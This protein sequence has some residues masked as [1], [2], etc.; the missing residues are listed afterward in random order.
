[1]AL[2][3]VHGKKAFTDRRKLRG[4]I[5]RRACEPFFRIFVCRAKREDF[6]R[7]EPRVIFTDGGK[8]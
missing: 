3:G 4:E 7:G 1:M 6:R 2:N 8:L 5:V